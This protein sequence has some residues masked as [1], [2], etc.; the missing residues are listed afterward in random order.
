MRRKTKRQLETLGLLAIIGGGV[1]TIAWLY[2]R[3]DRPAPRSDLARGPSHEAPPQPT[4]VTVASRDKSKRPPQP[5]PTAEPGA[6]PKIGPENPSVD[7]RKRAGE[8][9]DAAIATLEKKDVGNLIRGRDQLNEALAMGLG[10]ATATLARGKLGKLADRTIFSADVC[11]GDRL[12]GSYAMGRGQFL[13]HLEKIFR[14]PYML[15]EHCNNIKDASKIRAEQR[16][17]V[18]EGPL[19]AVVHKSEFRLDLYVQDLY[20]KSF[21]VGLGQ[22]DSTP[23][24]AWLVVDKV[25]NP[26]YTNPRTHEHIKADDP[27]NPLGER[28]IKLE[29]IRGDAVGQTSYG[30]HGTIEPDSIGKA[31]SLGC[32]RMHNKDVEFV[33]D[34]LLVRHSE[35]IVRE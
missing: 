31:A 6:R 8:L 13:V 9:Y 12:T 15:I 34:C 24:G 10:P 25:V 22:F 35:V 1:G 14:T 32:V 27:K 20:V 19:H 11:P 16:L 5:T 30:I 29:G 18:V 17:K 7:R 21:P 28:W 33:F 23:T 4:S 3:A 2:Q 26:P